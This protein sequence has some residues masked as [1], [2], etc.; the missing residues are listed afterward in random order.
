MLRVAQHDVRV[1]VIRNEV[2]MFFR[3]SDLW[4]VHERQ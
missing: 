2:K 1:I 4:K 3:N